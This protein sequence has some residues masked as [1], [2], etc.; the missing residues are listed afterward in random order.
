MYSFADDR[1][2]NVFQTSL[3]STMCRRVHGSVSQQAA[4][5]RSIPVV[6]GEALQDVKYEKAEGEGIAKVSVVLFVR[7]LTAHLCA[8]HCGETYGIN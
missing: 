7:P 4:S 5:W 2:V 1:R 3:Q 6:H 8:H